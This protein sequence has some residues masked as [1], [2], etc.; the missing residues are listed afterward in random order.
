M[1]V[2]K[3]FVIKSDGFMKICIIVRKNIAFSA[4]ISCFYEILKQ[5]NSALRALF[6]HVGRPQGNLNLADVGFVKHKHTKS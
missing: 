3:V 2:L 5:D 6:N 1:G 4:Y